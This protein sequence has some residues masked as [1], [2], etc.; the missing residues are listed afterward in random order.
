M[1]YNPGDGTGIVDEILTLCDANLTSYP[2]ATITRRI[3]Q[4]LEQVESWIRQADGVW[5]FDDEN[6]STIPEGTTDLVQGQSDYSFAN[7]FLD[8]DWVKVKNSSGYWQIIPPIDQSQI[9]R[10]LED[11]LIRA[12]FPMMYDKVGDTIRLYPAPDGGVTTLTGGMK[13]GFKRG[14]SEFATN[15]TTKTPG[16]ALPYHII[17]AYMASIPYCMAYK[18]DRV[19]WLNSK[20]GDT[21]PPTGLKRDIIDFYSNREKDSPKKM[22]M[23]AMPFR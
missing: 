16:F 4:S 20:V 12:A 23:R 15:D 9:D 19:A 11:W 13:V 8:I 17:L 22:T 2:I 18:K 6:N 14:A 3:N 10:P 1:Q 7:T 21:I 5:Q